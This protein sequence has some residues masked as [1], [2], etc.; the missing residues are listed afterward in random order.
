[1]VLIV[2]SLPYL[3]LYTEKRF[4]A[5]GLLVGSFFSS[6]IFHYNTTRHLFLSSYLNTI[7]SPTVILCVFPR[8]PPLCAS[9]SLVSSHFSS[10]VC[11]P[12]SRQTFILPLLLLD[13]NYSI[14]ACTTSFHP[15]TFTLNSL[16]HRLLLQSLLHHWSSALCPLLYPSLFFS[17]TSVIGSKTCLFAQD[18]TTSTASCCMLPAE[19]FSKGFQFPFLSRLDLCFVTLGDPL[20]ISVSPVVQSIVFFFFPHFIFLH[21]RP[22][23][24]PRQSSTL[25]TSKITTLLRS[26]QFVLHHQ[27]Y[28]LSFPASFLFCLARGWH[29]TE[30]TLPTGSAFDFSLSRRQDYDFNL[31]LSLAAVRDQPADLQATVDPNNLFV[32]NLSNTTRNPHT[33]YYFCPYFL[34]T[35]SLLLQFE[36]YVTFRVFG[37]QYSSSLATRSTYFEP[38]LSFYHSYFPCW[39]VAFLLAAH[40]Y[41]F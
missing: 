22:N 33:P 15:G 4:V 9:S 24:L 29:Y 40:L 11:L 23:S 12:T 34:H 26:R 18:F 20:V 30:S 19:D 35:A 17:F 6:A 16:F 3:L 28:T 13:N 10:S 1:M 32:V 2:N 36:R 8:Y 14:L 38:L 31:L 21:T 39:K 37:R 5:V 27:L 25:R 7:S 41:V